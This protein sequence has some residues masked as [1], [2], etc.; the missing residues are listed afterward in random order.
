M[1]NDGR[2]RECHACEKGEIWC[3][4]LR[5]TNAFKDLPGLLTDLSPNKFDNSYI[6][7]SIASNHH[8]TDIMYPEG[9]LCC[10]GK[11]NMVAWSSNR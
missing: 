5:V 7:A 8:R 10:K 3:V 1:G 4:F 6:H 11:I 2:K 9:L